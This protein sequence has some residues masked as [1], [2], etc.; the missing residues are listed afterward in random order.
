MRAYTDDIGRFG[1]AKKYAAFAGLVP[2]VQDSNE[3]IR[4]GKIT[5]RGPL[6]T[7]SPA[8]SLQAVQENG[9]GNP[10]CNRH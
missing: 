1:N 8:L 5:K 9:P 4:H 7:G 2:W 10:R 3:R 6:E